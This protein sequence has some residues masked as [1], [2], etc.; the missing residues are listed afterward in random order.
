VPEEDV[1]SMKRPGKITVLTVAGV[2]GAGHFAVAETDATLKG[3]K[4]EVPAPPAVSFV[5][6]TTSSTAVYV[7]TNTDTE[8]DDVRYDVD[9]PTII[10]KNVNPSKS[11]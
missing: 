4:N 10:R 3:K 2:F 9:Y 5:L 1:I 6:T 11:G 7:N 8:I